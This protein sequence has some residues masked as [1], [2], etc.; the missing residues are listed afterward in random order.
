MVLS[1][2]GPYRVQYLSGH[3]VSPNLIVNDL[4]ENFGLGGKSS[5]LAGTAENFFKKKN[6][7]KYYYIVVLMV[8]IPP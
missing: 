1:V 4:F 3:K 8:G 5:F 6:L 7:F 2:V